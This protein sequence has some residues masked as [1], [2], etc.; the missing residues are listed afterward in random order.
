MNKNMRFSW[1][2]IFTI[3]LLSACQQK[4]DVQQAD[5]QADIMTVNSAE[6]MSTQQVESY[7]T[8]TKGKIESESEIPVYSRLAEQIVMFAI[9]KPGQYVKKGQVVARLSDASLHDKIVHSRAKLEKAEFQYQAILMGQGYKRD[10]LDAAPDNI[11]RLARINS[12]YN[13][14]KAE[15]NELEHRLSYCTITAPVSGYVSQI[16]NTLYGAAQPGEA[17]FYLVDIEHLKV[18][19][20]VLE[21]ELAKYENGASLSVSTLTFPSEHHKATVSAVDPV[22]DDNGMVHIEATLEPHRHL[23]PGMTAFVSVGSPEEE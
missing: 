23:A 20:E 9:E 16:R 11:K 17:L 15:L 3:L 7:A 5:Q 12:G 19:F 6:S 8:V 10:Q 2:G 1:I 13:E 22:I 14:A 4:K 18:S 21:N